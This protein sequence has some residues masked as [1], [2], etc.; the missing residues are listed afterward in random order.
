[1]TTLP[2]NFS[3]TLAVLAETEPAILIKLFPTNPSID[4]AEKLEFDIETAP[5]FPALVQNIL[6]YK[7]EKTHIVLELSAVTYIDSTGLHVLHDWHKALKS[8]GKRL[9]LTQVP[10]FIKTLLHCVGLDKVLTVL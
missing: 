2:D 10:D 1:M 7:Q 4:T 8:D 5:Y 6:K 3:L 9:S